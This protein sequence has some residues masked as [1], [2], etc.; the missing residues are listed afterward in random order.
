VFSVLAGC[1]PLV[2]SLTV[3][4]AC[5]FDSDVNAAIYCGCDYGATRYDAMHAPRRISQWLVYASFSLA[6][7]SDVCATCHLCYF[8][9][10]N[11]TGIKT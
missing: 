8:F 4:P 9:Y 5:L 6:I 10:T 3:A 7:A 2:T 11:R 1:P